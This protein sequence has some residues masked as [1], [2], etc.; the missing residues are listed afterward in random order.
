MDYPFFN[1]AMLPRSRK[2][3]YVSDIADFYHDWKEN[4][5]R[6]FPWLLNVPEDFISDTFNV[7]G[8]SDQFPAFNLC[9]DVITG[10]T[11]VHAFVH[12]DQKKIIELLPSV[13]GMIHQRF[14]LTNEGLEGVRK[15][16]IKQIF[17][18][19]PRFECNSQPLLPIGLSSKIGVATVKTFCPRCRE[20]FEPRPKNSLDGAYFGPNM[21][22]VFLDEMR[23]T[24]RER[25]KFRPFVHTAFGFKL[26]KKYF[27]ANNNEL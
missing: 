8:L 15:K 25:K 3:N 24:T 26:R 5:L 17:G 11:S 13:Y 23:L 22:H 4:Y 19:C 12:N 21:P 1:D 20:I 6:N 16:F 27:G 9:C 14:L 10:K 7:F 2:L 18:N